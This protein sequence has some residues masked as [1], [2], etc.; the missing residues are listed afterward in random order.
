MLDFHGFLWPTFAVMFYWLLHLNYLLF[1]H[2]SKCHYESLKLKTIYHSYK[3]YEDDNHQ[4][5][6]LTL[7]ETKFSQ[8]K[9]N[10]FPPAGLAKIYIPNMQITLKILDE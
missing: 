5:N 3:A 6:I 2:A 9:I 4:S 8:Y 1:L 7:P 10:T